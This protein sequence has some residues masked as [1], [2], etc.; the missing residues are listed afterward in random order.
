MPLSDLEL[1]EYILDERHLRNMDVKS[2]SFRKWDRLKIAIGG[3]DDEKENDYAFVKDNDA[4]ND[5]IDVALLK[6]I[7][8]VCKQRWDAMLNNDDEVDDAVHLQSKIMTSL[9]QIDDS[10]QIHK[11]TQKFKQISKFLMKGCGDMTQIDKFDDDEDEEVEEVSESESSSDAEDT[12]EQR[13]EMLPRA[14]MDMLLDKKAMTKEELKEI[15]RANKKIVKAANR[16]R[17]KHKMPKKV[18]KRK[19]KVAR[20]NAGKSVWK[21]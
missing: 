20:L 10:F 19:I 3:D 7:E 4:W 9:F 1:F 13:V 2:F 17:R 6:R 5:V 11:N 12:E 14:P 15:R 16:E 21:K 18:K 8:R